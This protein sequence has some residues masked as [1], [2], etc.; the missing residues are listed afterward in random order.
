M[1]VCVCARVRAHTHSLPSLVD[2][3]AVRGRERGQGKKEK[4]ISIFV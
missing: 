2:K 4:K 1:C 3:K